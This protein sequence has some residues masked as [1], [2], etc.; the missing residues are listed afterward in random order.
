[1]TTDKDARIKELEAQLTQMYEA[2]NLL[3]DRLKEFTDA[4]IINGGEVLLVNNLE[5]ERDELKAEV[6]KLRSEANIN[7]MEVALVQ[8][9]KSELLQER[10]ELK[11]EVKLQTSQLNLYVVQASEEI[12]QLRELCKEMRSALIGAIHGS[13]SLIGKEY[14]AKD[15]I[16]KNSL[17]EKADAILGEGNDE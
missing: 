9:S 4:K 16:Q 15:A 1:M 14:L 10:D 3:V 13:Y 6:Q 11:A 7:R 8:T 17:L 12:N 5:Q 2:K